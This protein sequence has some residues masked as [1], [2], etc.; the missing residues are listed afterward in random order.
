MLSQA[1]HRVMQEKCNIHDDD[2]DNSD[3]SS[4]MFF[5]VLFLQTG[6]HSPLQIKEQRIKTEPKLSNDDD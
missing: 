3:G 4:R 1:S 5:S 6:A 2:D